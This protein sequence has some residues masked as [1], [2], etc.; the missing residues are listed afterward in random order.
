MRTAVALLDCASPSCC[1]GSSTSC[2]TLATRFLRPDTACA[3]AR[4]KRHT[5]VQARWQGLPRQHASNSTVAL[6]VSYGRTLP[7]HVNH[8]RRCHACRLTG[9]RALW[10]DN[11]RGMLLAGRQLARSR[12]PTCSSLGS[13]LTRLLRVARTGP[14]SGSSSCGCTEHA[15]ARIHAQA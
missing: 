8:R 11:T 3:F 2:L 13:C 10:Y 5:K 7:V 4:V 9:S 6:V 15:S 14:P 12:T 1:C